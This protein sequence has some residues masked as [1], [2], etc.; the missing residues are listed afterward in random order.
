M[1]SPYPTLRRSGCRSARVVKRWQ[2]RKQEGDRLDRAG[3]MSGRERTGKEMA[4]MAKSVE[5]DPQVELVLR[6]RTRELGLEIGM[7]RGRGMNS[8]DIGR[9]LARD[10]GIGRGRGLSR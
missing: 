9:E 8:G 10:L 1:L 5:R 2:G 7:G 6:N 3:D 4:G